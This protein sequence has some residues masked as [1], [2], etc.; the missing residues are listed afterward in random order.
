MEEETADRPDV[1]IHPPTVFF[2]A[3]LIGFTMRAFTGG[4]LPMPRVF[5]EG[6]GGLLM[7][8]G[9]AAA[10]SAVSAFAE[11]GETL[12]PS[13]PSNELLTD[14]MYRYSRNPIYLAMVLFGVGFGFATLNLWI[15][16]TTAAA[17]AVFHYFVI[18]PEESYLERKFGSEFRDYKAQVRR[19]L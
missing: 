7:L 19:W 14:G 10:I 4:M 5:G 8:A 12:R 9:L 16:L 18:P 3:L 1:S 15:I 6:V 13:T 11:S 2:A 17:G